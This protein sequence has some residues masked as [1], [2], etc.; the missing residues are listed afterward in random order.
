M[1]Y[2]WGM[3]F[4]RQI[5][6]KLPRA[7]SDVS[8]WEKGEKGDVGLLI[9][10]CRMKFALCEGT[11]SVNLLSVYG[12]LYIHHEPMNFEGSLFERTWR[13]RLY[14]DPHV[15]ALHL[16]PTIEQTLQGVRLQI[17]CH[18]PQQRGQ[19]SIAMQIIQSV[20]YHFFC[21]LLPGDVASPPFSDTD[22][23]SPLT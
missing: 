4:T 10:T 1:C 20:Y 7:K 15:I 9:V 3:T 12:N 21:S 18:I 8:M 5:D 17:I 11:K 2:R 13:A 22:C 23:T 6:N 14:V 19:A 16:M